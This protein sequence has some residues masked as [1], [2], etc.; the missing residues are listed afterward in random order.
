ME[1]TSPQANMQI[2]PDILSLKHR[3]HKHLLTGRSQ[4]SFS[5]QESITSGH[6]I[7]QAMDNYLL[8]DKH[9][10]VAEII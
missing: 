5:R 3:S 2:N 6:S 9:M 8:Y 7:S 1:P 10:E 4:R